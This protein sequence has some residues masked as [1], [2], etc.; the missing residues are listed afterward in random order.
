MNGREHCPT[1]FAQVL[2]VFPSD[3][4]EGTQGFHPIS[5]VRNDG[6]CEYVQKLA[7]I[8]EI[9]YPLGHSKANWSFGNLNLM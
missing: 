9:D 2:S 7:G 4:F 6:F 3:G 5:Q 8:P 1:N